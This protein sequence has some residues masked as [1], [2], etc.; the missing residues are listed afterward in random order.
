MTGQT[1]ATKASGASA[2]LAFLSPHPPP[3]QQPDSPEFS[4]VI[5]QALTAK[6]AGSGSPA[7]DHSPG[8][9]VSS[10]AKPASADSTDPDPS[11]LLLALLAQPLLVPQA[12][13]EWHK[14]TGPTASLIPSEMPASKAADVIANQAASEEKPAANDAEDSNLKYQK[15]PIPAPKPTP[16]KESNL[17]DDSVISS[18]SSSKPSPAQAE[19][20][21]ANEKTA[22]AS[23]KP[24]IPE[25][26]DGPE[27]SPTGTSAATSSERMNYSAER[28]EIAG[29]T[30]QKLPPA[31]VAA[32]TAVDAGGGSGQRRAK[33]SLDL[34]WHDAPAQD[35]VISDSSA[36][37][38]SGAQESEA[39]ASPSS[40]QLGRLEQMISREV[41]TLRE[42]GAESLGV[43][44]RVDANTQ[45]FLQ[46]TNHNGQLQA[47]LRCERGE[48]SAPDAQWTQLQ[49]AL[50]RQHVQLLPP[51]SGVNG[52]SQQAS[53]HPQRQ[54]PQSREEALAAGTAVA[55]AQ[56]RKQKQPHRS[57]QSWESWA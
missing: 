36:K 23:A 38:M 44:L 8:A 20:S 32:V 33:S 3:V 30:E 41:V 1:P 37:T 7:E 17:S 12:L 2:L 28:N 34:S 51:G 5:L 54:L 42:R 43:S 57:R 22:S 45:L 25:K 24:Q 15:P 56:T 14:A 11:S 35:L 39:A 40:G 47:S 26:A 9:A 31:A 4:A 52:G 55:P 53:D 10:P 19:A 50:A 13:P 6:S 29:G 16:A 49:Q 18:G 27:A 46:L 21:V 48:F